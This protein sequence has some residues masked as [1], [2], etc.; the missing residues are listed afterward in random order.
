MPPSLNVCSLSYNCLSSQ[1]V[2]LGHVQGETDVS[3]T[4]TALRFIWISCPDW[5]MKRM[6]ICSVQTQLLVFWNIHCHPW[7]SPR[8][9]DISLSLIQI[10]LFLPASTTILSNLTSTTFFVATTL[11]PI[12]LYSFIITTLYSYL[13]LGTMEF[14][15][16]WGISL[17]HINHL[18]RLLPTL[19]QWFSIPEDF[20]PPGDIWQCLRTWC[21]WQLAGEVKRMLRNIL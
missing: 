7:I 17:T 2:S 1:R 12:Q 3:G 14:L 19:K 13:P 11:I 6:E 10:S 18:Y 20:V 8:C 9:Q 4:L 21:Y 15:F 5:R 16:N